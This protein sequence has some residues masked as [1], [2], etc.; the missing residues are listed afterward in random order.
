MKEPNQAGLVFNFEEPSGPNPKCMVCGAKRA[1]AILDTTATSLRQFVEQVLKGQ[2]GFN[3]PA[4][5]NKDSLYLETDDASI[6]SWDVPI[7]ALA[8]GG[9]QDG[10]M[11][12]V[13]DLDQD[14]GE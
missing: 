11:V 13:L 4:L 5:D 9:M 1:T 10:A 7:A 12:A 8:G 6:T 3:N 2:L 14:L